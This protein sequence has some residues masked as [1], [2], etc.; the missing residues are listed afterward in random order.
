MEFNI[1]AR[2]LDKMAKLLHLHSFKPNIPGEKVKE[3]AFVNSSL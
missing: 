3:N 2:K 1:N